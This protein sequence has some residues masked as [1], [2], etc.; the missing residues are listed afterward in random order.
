MISVVLALFAAA[1][2]AVASV[3]QRRTARSL[4]DKQAFRPSL[5]LTLIRYPG[6]LCGI[7]AL[8]LGFVFQAAALSAGG[9]TLVQPVLV[10]ELPITMVLVSR[11]FGT[12][13]DRR[14]WFAVGTMTVGV[15]TF[16]ASAAPGRG[17]STPGT[18][19]WVLAVV[20]TV[21]V[22]T[23]LVMAARLTAGPARAAVL[24]VAA[25]IGFAFTATFIKESTTIFERNPGEL[26]TSWEPY[27]MVIAG[28]CSLFLL[29]NALQS[30]PLVAAQPALTIS[31][32][33][34]GILYGTMMFGEQVR[35][36][37]WTLLEAL[38]IALI[39]FGSFLLAQS[40]ILGERQARATA[41][42][43]RG[44]SR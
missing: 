36:G 40:P 31:D 21:G 16:L 25:G 43:A 10:V 41:A 33:V 20:V 39:I 14:S 37:A 34:A 6:W 24:G 12:R 15:A 35:T 38:G 2:N 30:G 11:V 32:P 9:L 29:Q 7:G 1:S 3:L 42:R 5:I 18:T 28:L 19:E 44:R 17:H 26:A 4:P 13:L 22:V 8:I 23:G 27:A